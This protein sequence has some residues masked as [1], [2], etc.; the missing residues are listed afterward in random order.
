MAG[1]NRD[2]RLEAPEFPREIL[3]DW[4]PMA[5]GDDVTSVP[6]EH[7][8]EAPVARGQFAACPSRAKPTS[9]D[10]PHFSWDLFDRMDSGI[11]RHVIV[12]G[13]RREADVGSCSRASSSS[14]RS[15]G[16]TAPSIAGLAPESARAG[17]AGFSPSRTGVQTDASTTR[18]AVPPT[19]A[20]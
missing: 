1:S 2:S 4:N 11:H 20:G 19:A 9:R 5:R 3:N 6:E 18:D 7:A 15:M 13:P 10:G 17:T 12:V 8:G 14:S 16:P